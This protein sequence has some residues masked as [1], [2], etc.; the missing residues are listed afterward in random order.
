[1][2]NQTERVDVLAVMASDASEAKYERVRVQGRK[3]MLESHSESM[4]AQEA[5]AELIRTATKIAG[6]CWLH[7]GNDSLYEMQELRAA[8]ARIGGDV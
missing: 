5:V 4:A 2:S 6:R 8:L 7:M 3:Q 1:M